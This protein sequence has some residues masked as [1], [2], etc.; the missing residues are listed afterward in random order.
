MSNKYSRARTKAKQR[1]GYEEHPPLCRN[2][3][4]YRLPEEGRPEAHGLKALK[5]VGAK[6]ALGNF[7]CRPFAI[8]DK[9]AGEDGSVLE[10]K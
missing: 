8:C 4:H 7:E 6:C 3:I 10:N 1:Q 5:Y 9:W 2:C